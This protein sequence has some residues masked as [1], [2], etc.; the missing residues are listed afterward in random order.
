MP[1]LIEA[2]KDKSGEVR[3]QAAQS[4]GLIGPDAKYAVPALQEAAKDSNEDV[5]RVAADALK[6]IQQ[7]K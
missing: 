5:A 2:L 4:L 6:S 7:D 1:A 3:L